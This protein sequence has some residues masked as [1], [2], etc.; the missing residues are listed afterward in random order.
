MNPVGAWTTVK[1]GIEKSQNFEAIYWLIN[2]EWRSKAKPQQ[3]P[4]PPHGGSGV[5]Y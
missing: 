4:G 3:G 2:D 5:H 1:V